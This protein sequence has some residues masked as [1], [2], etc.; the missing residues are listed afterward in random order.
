MLR[1]VSALVAALALASCSATITE[2]DCA[3][4]A[5]SGTWEV[6]FSKASGPDSCPALEKT[7]DLP[8][9]EENCGCTE[10]GI[11]FKSSA[12]TATSDTC[13][14]R[15]HEQCPAY[16]LDCRFVEVDSPTHASGDC[17]YKVGSDQCGYKAEWTKQ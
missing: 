1:F 17:F 13:T 11:V 14:I 15:F 12:N 4:A 5:E 10:A 6:T 8:N 3:K 2:A 7:F 9:C 16:E